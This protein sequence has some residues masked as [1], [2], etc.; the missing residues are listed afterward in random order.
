MELLTNPEIWI[1]LLTLT[2]LE[3]VLGIDN[4][5]FISILANKLP[6]DQRDEFYALW[7]EFEERE[8]PE[9]RLANAMDRLMPSLHNFENGGGTWGRDGITH[10]R[11]VKRLNPIDDGSHELW[12]YIENLL[13]D[14]VA[15]G[16]ITV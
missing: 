5:V 14:A 4:I 9:A 15:Q 12:T 7:L 6:D 1:A 3:I 2:A 10:E 13:T 16:M 8:T 11:V